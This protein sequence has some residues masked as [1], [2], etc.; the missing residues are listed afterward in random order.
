MIVRMEMARTVLM[1]I[2]TPLLK[3][4]LRPYTVNG[5]N[6]L[7]SIAH[8]VRPDLEGYEQKRG[9]ALGRIREKFAGLQDRSTVRLHDR[10]GLHLAVLTPRPAARGGR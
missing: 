10:H 5:L 9:P 8:S 3:N 6:H 1:F 4:I 7:S 2:E